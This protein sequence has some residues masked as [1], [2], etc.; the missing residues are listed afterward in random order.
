MNICHY[1]PITATLQIYSRGTPIALIATSST[2]HKEQNTII[3]YR[4]YNWNFLRFKEALMIKKHRPTL[5]CGLMASKG[6]QLFRLHFMILFG[7][8]FVLLISN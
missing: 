6:L 8:L 5:N 2:Y 1:V 7:I 4:G 3:L